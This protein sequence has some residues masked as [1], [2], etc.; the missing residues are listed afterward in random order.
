VSRSSK[1]TKIALNLKKG[2]CIYVQGVRSVVEAVVHDKDM[3]T[4]TITVRQDDGKRIITAHWR[5][6]FDCIPP[7]D[8]RWRYGLVFWLARKLGV[9]VK[10]AV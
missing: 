1:S 10:K 3:R 6:E 9:K 7:K 4:Y 2:D 8:K 5:D